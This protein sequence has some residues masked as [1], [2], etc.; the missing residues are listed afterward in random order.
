[1]KKRR[2]ITVVLFLAFTSLIFYTLYSCNKANVTEKKKGY[3]ELMILDGKADID[4]G[5]CLAAADIDGDGK[6]EMFIGGDG[7]LVWY[8]PDTF[9]K[10]V[11]A[12]GNFHVGL[13]LEDVDG[14]GRPEV[15]VGEESSK[16]ET[17][18]LLTEDLTIYSLLIWMVI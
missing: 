13:V 18:M 7:G 9:E 15:F 12:K 4:V 5:N 3:W 16:P 1:M 6:Q 17:W 8:R 2:T 10:G 11:I 14:C